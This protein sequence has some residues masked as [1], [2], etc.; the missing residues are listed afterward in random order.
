MNNRH[1]KHVSYSSQIARS[2]YTIAKFMRSVWLLSTQLSPNHDLSNPTLYYFFGTCANWISLSSL[3]FHHIYITRLPW[4]KHTADHN[5]YMSQI[6]LSSKAISSYS[7]IQSHW[8]FGLNL[9]LQEYFPDFPI[10]YPNELGKP[11][12][13]PTLIAASL[14]WHFSASIFHILNLEQYIKHWRS[15]F[16]YRNIFNIL[17]YM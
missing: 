15:H 12:M 6:W 1:I 10:R 4:P 2:R 13:V 7:E 5:I 17:E 9:W 14:Q 8:L 3:S 11:C 16:L